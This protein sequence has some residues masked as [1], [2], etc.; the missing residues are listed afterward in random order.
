MHASHVPRPRPTHSQDGRHHPNSRPTPPPH[1]PTPAGPPV[2]P[3]TAA[4]RIQ[5]LATQSAW[6]PELPPLHRAALLLTNDDS[7]QAWQ[8]AA[9]AESYYL[10]TADPDDVDTRNRFTLLA[11]ALTVLSL[12]ASPGTP[13]DLPAA[14]LQATTDQLVP[15]ESTVAI[16]VRTSEL[17][18]VPTFATALEVGEVFGNPADGSPL[19][20]LPGTLPLSRPPLQRTS[21]GQGNSA[22]RPTTCPP[23][24]SR[25]KLPTPL[26]PPS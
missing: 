14:W 4:S 11:H 18:N 21:Y 3:E 9:T 25:S 12:H 8:D 10:Q 24:T 7:R 17:S 13:P 1:E 23:P 6:H 16:Q 15:P 22:P 20:T 26:S 19:A 2:S 5:E